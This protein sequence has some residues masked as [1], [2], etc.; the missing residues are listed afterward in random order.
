[1]ALHVIDHPLARVLITRLR[2]RETSS[3]SFRM[4]C[5][6]ITQ[7]LII[8]A[9]KSM[10]VTRCHIHTPLEKADGFGWP[11]D[12]AIIPIIR[13]GI[14]MTDPILE[15]FP[16]AVVGFVGLERDEETAIARAYYRNIPSMKG[17]KVFIV[18]P[19][20]ATGGTAL[21][22]VG[23]CLGEGA[24]DMALITIIAA[25]EGVEAVEGRY[26]ELSIYTAALDRELD[27]QKY[28]LPGLGDF[29]D[30]LFNTG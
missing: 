25:P 17:R 3:E 20:L 7:L 4:A 9:T 14:S 18:D 19:M 24:G 30:R 12:I 10:P 16:S 21:Q 8:E 13:A 26:P 5:R 28:I 6:G 11:M 15:F 2:N 27:G 1:M 22:T 29:G 23:F